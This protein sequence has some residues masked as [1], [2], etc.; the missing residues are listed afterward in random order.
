MKLQHIA[1]LVVPAA[2]VAVIGVMLAGQ[3]RDG[4][5]A[6]TSPNGV[7]FSDFKGYEAWQVI[8]PSEPDDAGGCGSS[9]AP[10]CIKALLG[11]P[12]MIQAYADGFP[13]G[14]RPAPD[15]AAMVKVEWNKRHAAGAPGSAY[16]VTLPGPLVQVSFMVK[17]RKRFPATDGWGYATFKRDTVSGAWRTFGDGPEFANGCHAS[18][19]L[20]KA[21]DFDF[22]RYAQR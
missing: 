16:P 7:A 2:A 18:H 14:G 1:A 8:G 4:R 17:D 9:P 5:F 11:N 13:A 10:G 21:S 15:G 20:V 22:S 6:L 12:A 3:S 19:T